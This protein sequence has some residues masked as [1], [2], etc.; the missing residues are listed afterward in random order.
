MDEETVEDLDWVSLCDRR[1]FYH[2][3][4]EFHCFLYFVEMV[5]KKIT[6]IGN[7]REMKKGQC[8][9]R[10]RCVVGWSNIK[11]TIR[12]ISRSQKTEKEIAVMIS[13]CI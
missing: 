9:A 10:C 4:T 1:G 8:K 7:L 3:R 11:S 6:S 5:V 13:F 12:R 2:V